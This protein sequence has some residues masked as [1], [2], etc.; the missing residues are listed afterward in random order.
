MQL[1]NFSLRQK[2]WLLIVPAILY[3]LLLTI[4]VIQQY[5][6][7]SLMSIS[8]VLMTFVISG[9][10][11]WVSS[12]ISHAPNV[13]QENAKSKNPQL[14]N[15][16][17]RMIDELR[18]VFS[19]LAAGNLEQNVT[20]KYGDDLAGLKT[21]I[22]AVLNQL[23]TIN[24]DITII[25]ESASKGKL[26]QRISL[27]NKQ[28]FFKN[29]S[30]KIN[31]NLDMNQLLIEDVINVFKAISEGNLNQT[32][33]RDYTG[34]LQ[35]LKQT[36]NDSVERIKNISFEIKDVLSM[37]AEGQFD[38]RIE[39]D[40]KQGFFQQL[41]QCVNANVDVN[42]NII[43][44][45]THVFV[46]VSNGDLTQ[47]MQYDYTGNFKQ[48]KQDVNHTVS[49]LD[50]M[51]NE[52]KL[53]VDA[54]A[55]GVLDKR[56][57][58]D[59]KQG[60]FKALAQNLNNSLDVNQTM[61]EEMMRIHSAISTG[62]LT[63]NLSA[64]YA[65]L[66]DQLKQ[67]VNT[68]I[69]RLNQ[70]V[71]QVGDAIIAARQGLFD[72][73]IPIDDKQG[74][75][76]D[77][78]ENLNQH[79]D[80]HQNMTV[81]LTWIFTAMADGDLSQTINNHYDGRLAEL[82]DVVNQTVTRLNNTLLELGQSNKMLNVAA[83]EILQSNLNLSQR[84]EQQ[85]AALQEITTNMQQMTEAVQ[86]NADNTQQANQLSIN[87]Q[88]HTEEAGKVVNQVT[89]AM[90]QINSSSR[91]ISDISSVIDDIA[92][93]IN[94]TALSVAVEVARTGDKGTGF[95][96]V[97]NDVRQLAQHSSG[98]AREMKAL[99]EDN[100]VKVSEG[101][102]LVE[103]SG[104]S[105][106]E[107]QLSMNKVGESVAE[108][109]ILSREQSEEILQ[110]NNAV[111]QIDEMTQQNANLVKEVSANGDNMHKQV[112]SLSELMGF[113]KLENESAKQ[114]DNDIEQV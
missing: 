65:G 94:R 41:G 59:S 47:T 49:K 23:R 104:K 4:I 71:E 112:A 10:M 91:K 77:I 55:Q 92:F 25:T 90:D 69:D 84:S 96:A 57:D 97:I 19:A 8:F 42:Q 95:V 76:L 87:T 101:V 89:D 72:N 83:N 39:T 114:Q 103:Q 43:Q 17:Q 54:S 81:E 66:L 44:E 111:T 48:L 20:S 29:I 37:A 18:T 88:K 99:I 5:A 2:L 15:T 31:Q 6:Q 3:L 61:I 51:L 40:D 64:D 108:I 98:V 82:K 16:Y 35:Q 50:K 93:K 9:L 27:E 75:F 53:V 106:E 24:S 80:T 14:T 68:V 7:T 36:V 38:K 45:M 78:S 33:Q 28:G 1:A 73:R 107:V 13:A 46:A 56:V 21:D 67:Q 110:I 62:D 32:M 58:L 109:A 74:F 11:F 85:V 70:V 86:Q 22:N 63:Q 34:K 79:L 30:E 12:T 100:T 102:A 105:L 52:I 60:F 113:F 26:E